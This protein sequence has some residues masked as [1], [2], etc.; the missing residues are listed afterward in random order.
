MVQIIVMEYECLCP[1]V[2]WLAT[3]ARRDIEGEKSTKMNLLPR[4]N[5]ARL[6]A[7][8]LA[9]VFHQCDDVRNI[10]DCASVFHL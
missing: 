7:N 10:Y 9:S 5:S 3:D 4:I 2:Q 6:I 1:I 8:N